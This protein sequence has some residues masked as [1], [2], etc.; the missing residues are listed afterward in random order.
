[1]LG[2]FSA[3]VSI[4]LVTA[5]LQITRRAYGHDDVIVTWADIQKDL[6]RLSLRAFGTAVLWV[7]VVAFLVFVFFAIGFV[8]LI[9]FGL[10]ASS[11]AEGA[12]ANAEEVVGVF[13]IF[14]FFIG[15][16]LLFPLLLAALPFIQS[17]QLAAVLEEE[18]PWGEALKE[19][20]RLAR[21]KFGSW[22][23]ALLVVLLGNLLLS[24]FLTVP[25]T[26]VRNLLLTRSDSVL[27]R[28]LAMPLGFY[29]G[30]VNFA[31]T[32]GALLFLGV[33]YLHFKEGED[34]LARAQ[35][36]EATAL[37]QDPAATHG[38]DEPSPAPSP[39]G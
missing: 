4:V 2:L 25:A 31:L 14:G 6:A 13:A 26:F 7:L 24:L 36:D 39:E 15:L 10:F 34:A 3:L 1:M 28:L 11:V 9:T 23:A 32:L 19:G 30:M 29:Q 38:E 22:L 33:A 35:T 21:R 16:C 5:A 27:G 17:T 12:A 20:V 37:P 18:R 8:L